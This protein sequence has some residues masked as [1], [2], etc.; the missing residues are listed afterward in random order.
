MTPG[1]LV[2]LNARNGLAYRRDY[3]TEHVSLFLSAHAHH[4]DSYF[5]TGAMPHGA[6]LRLLEGGIVA[7]VDAS[8]HKPLSLIHI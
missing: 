1:A 4:A 5:R 7:V 8:S 2:V 3:P 6:T